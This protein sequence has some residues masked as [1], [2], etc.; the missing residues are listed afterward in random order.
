M[1]FRYTSLF[2]NRLLRSMGLNLETQCVGNWNVTPRNKFH[3]FCLFIEIKVLRYL[4]DKFHLWFERARRIETAHKIHQSIFSFLCEK[5]L[6]R[7]EI[8]NIFCLIL[9]QIFTWREKKKNDTSCSNVSYIDYHQPVV[10]D[11]DAH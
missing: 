7:I 11:N 2:F 9:T 8:W 3:F 6:S 4:L 5:V 1:R 10:F